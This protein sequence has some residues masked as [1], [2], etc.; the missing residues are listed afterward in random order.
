M[1]TFSKIVNKYKS[2]VITKASLFAQV[3]NHLHFQLGLISPYKLR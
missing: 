3:D 1:R 2:K